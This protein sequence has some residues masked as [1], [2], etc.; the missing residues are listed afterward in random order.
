MPDEHDTELLQVTYL[1]IGLY[2]EKVTGFSRIAK[3]KSEN[4]RNSTVGFWNIFVAILLMID[5]LIDNHY[6][7]M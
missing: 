2:Q 4:I 1:L 6:F 3:K 5:N 7:R